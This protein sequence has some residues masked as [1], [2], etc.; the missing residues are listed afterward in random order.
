[1]WNI[2]KL[3]DVC[4]ISSSKRIFAKEYQNVGIPFFIEEKRLLKK[5]KGMMS[6]QNYLFLLKDMKK[7]RTNMIYLVREIF[8]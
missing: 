2:M 8:F 6:Q 1:M 3:G 5:I 7:L 4:T